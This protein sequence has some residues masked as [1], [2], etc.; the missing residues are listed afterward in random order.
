[1]NILLY[2]HSCP[3]ETQSKPGR[4]S[5]KKGNISFSFR[6]KTSMQYDH[7]RDVESPIKGNA[8]EPN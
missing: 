7:N 8:A 2:K 5:V 4:N 6:G 3:F 1:M